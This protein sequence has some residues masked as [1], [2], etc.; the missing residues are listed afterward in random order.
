[1][2]SNADEV[3]KFIKDEDVKFVDVRFCDLPGVMQHFNVPAESF[4]RRLLH[5]RPDVRR[6]L[7]PRLPGDP[8]VRHEAG[9]GPDD[10]VHRPVPRREDADRELLRSSTRSPD[11][12]YSR[13]PRNIA[14]KAE[15]YLKSHRHRRHRVLRR[16]GRVLHLRRRA[17]RDQAERRLLLHRLR[18]GGLE[19][20]PR[21][22]GRQPRLQ[23]ARTRAAT[24]P[25]RRSTTSPTCAT[26]CASSLE[27]VGLDVERSHHEVGTAGQA[28]D[29]LPLRH[30]AA[31]RRRHHEVQV[32]R[33]ERRLARRQDRDLHAEADLRRQ[34]LGHAHATSRSGRTASRCS[35]TRAATAACPTSR[36]GTSAACSSTP[37]RCW[38]S[39][40]R[41]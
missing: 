11:E 39:P 13:D 35:T 27:E 22:G 38:R 24:S 4:D 40:T 6:L 10:G 5:R 14:R 41:R 2:F 30:A 33:Q 28:G 18:R 15:A 32:R 8:R 7:D 3:L 29:Q 23:D 16:R 34:R 17:L 21:R 31:V 37:R 25:S 1:M 36:A 12:A 26:R 19:H 9:P 20:R